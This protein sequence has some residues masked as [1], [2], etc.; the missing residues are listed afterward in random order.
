M[1]FW[2]A[3]C[4]GTGTMDI[5]DCKSPIDASN[6]SN[7]NE[8]MLYNNCIRIFLSNEMYGVVLVREL[9]V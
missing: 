7:A 6:S 8:N 4:S 1:Q 2:F 3:M 9:P 5:C